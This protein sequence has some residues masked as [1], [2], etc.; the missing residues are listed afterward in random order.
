MHTYEALQSQCFFFHRKLWVYSQLT[1]HQPLSPALTASPPCV[2]PRSGPAANIPYPSS[3]R[4]R[5]TGWTSF[6]NIPSGH[7]HRALLG[8]EQTGAD[9]PA[10]VAGE[11]PEGAVGRDL[12]Q[13]SSGLPSGI[14]MQASVSSQEATDVIRKNIKS[15][16]YL[17]GGYYK[18]YANQLQLTSS[19]PVASIK[20]GTICQ[21][22]YQNDPS[23]GVSMSGDVTL[24]VQ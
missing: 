17:W 7:R 4:L 23:L 21:N 22:C 8:Q 18:I 5:V 13:I 10:L 6:V 3:G 16:N 12:L 2:S 1:H 15:E 11:L 20:L 9:V 14:S 19:N 24:L